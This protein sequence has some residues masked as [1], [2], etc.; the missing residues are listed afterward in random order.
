MCAGFGGPRGEQTSQHS[1]NYIAAVMLRVS[2]GPCVAQP[3]SRCP[4]PAR[5]APTGTRTN[6]HVREHAPPFCHVPG[7][8]PFPHAEL[9]HFLC[10]GGGGVGAISKPLYVCVILSMSVMWYVC[11]CVG[12]K[13]SALS[14]AL[15]F[16]AEQWGS[17]PLNDLLLC[18]N[19]CL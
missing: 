4:I 2:M 6:A 5:T 13:C 17:L 18:A 7:C 15:F 9:Q 11:V 14:K 8:H 12:G 1:A 19:S 3:R 10:D 16:Q